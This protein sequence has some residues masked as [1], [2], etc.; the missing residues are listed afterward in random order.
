MVTG[1]SPL[2]PR[3]AWVLRKVHSMPDFSQ[4]AHG[5]TFVHRILRTLQE[6]H[7]LLANRSRFAFGRGIALEA[8]SVE[9]I[10][11]Q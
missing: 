7:A 6:S 11:G 9:E 3:W 2:G 1:R 8:A 10:G 4:A 5:A